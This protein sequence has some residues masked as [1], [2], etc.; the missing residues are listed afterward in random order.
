MIDRL[1]QAISRVEDA[2][3]HAEQLPVEEQ[4]A[5]AARIEGMLSDLRWEQLL[6]DPAR[7]QSVDTLAEEAFAEFRAGKTRPLSDVFGDDT[8]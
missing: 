6:A 4:D 8:L 7:S 5:L 3:Q 2:A 1:R